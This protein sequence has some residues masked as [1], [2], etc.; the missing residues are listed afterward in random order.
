M[1]G[2]LRVDEITDEAGTG[3][4]SFP[5]SATGIAEFFS[6]T[7]EGS[8]G[9]SDWTGSDPY[10]AVMTVTGILATDR[11]IA[12]IDF[13][14]VSFADVPDVQADWAL[15]YRVVASGDDE[16]TFYATEEPTEDLIIQIQVTR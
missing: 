16:L 7:I 14:S 3:S 5:N 6:T 9:S 4:P 10:T 15:V 11:P 8:S 2:Q 13:S 12:D 1:A